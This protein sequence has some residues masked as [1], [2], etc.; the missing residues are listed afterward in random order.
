M[1]L[2]KANE[3]LAKR[4]KLFTQARQLYD[5][6]TAEGRDLSSEEQVEFD[7]KMDECDRLDA[8]ARKIEED[9]ARL[10]SRAEEREITQ[11]VLE[12]AGR[13]D[14]D[15]EQYEER[16][17]DAFWT[18]MRTGT[19]EMSR[20]TR[21]QRE[22]L[23]ETRA[24]AKQVVGT[25]AAGGYLV[26]EDFR[27]ELITALKQ[28]GGIRQAGRVFETATGRDLPWPRSDDTG[29]GAKLVGEAVK[30]T[31]STGVPFGSVTLGAHMYRSGPIKISFELEQD[32]AIGIESIVRDAM[33]IRFGRKM[34]TDM[35]VGSTGPAGIIA[36]TSGS[37]TISGIPVSF[38]FLHDLE[39]SVDP[40]YRSLPGAG[41]MFNDDTRKVLRKI[42]ESTAAADR[43]MYLWEPR[44][45]AGSPDMLLGYPVY[46]NQDLGSFATAGSTTQPVLF[47]AFNYYM[48]RDVRGMFMLRLTER[49]ADEGVFALQGYMR[50]DGRAVQPSTT[51]AQKAFRCI[52]ATT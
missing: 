3:L 36:A 27:A 39:A 18:A 2:G 1:S 15:P 7:R 42:R 17:R 38:D 10:E 12:R 11:D 9:L 34:N 28:Y 13:R 33:R 30:S 37:A 6:A 50:C 19:G 23:T 44:L 47:G 43:G 24:L 51:P 25:P 32:D 4:A 26:P 20:L 35:T 45:T 48:V 41:W 31:N 14:L 5:D 46:I 29:N 52:R 21:E 22:T 8:R 40:A 49:Y 16:Y